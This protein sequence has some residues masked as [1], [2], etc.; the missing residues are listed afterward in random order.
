[1]SDKPKAGFPVIILLCVFLFIL[2]YHYS[3]LFPFTNNAFVV[4]NVRP[5]TANVKGYITNIYIKNEQEVKKG[6]PLFTVFKAPYELA[7]RKAVSD[8]QEAKAQLLLFNK[9]VEKT[10]YLLQAQK[11]LYEKFRFDYEHNHSALR[12]HAV[13]KLTVNTMLKE[14]NAALSKLKA[15][16]KELEVNQQQVIVQ[17]KK[18]DSLIAVMK[19][20]KIDLDE[21]TVYA[22]QNGAVQDM[23]VALGTP[24]KTRKPVFAIADTDTLFIQAN[25]N[26]TDLRRVQPGDKVSIFPRMYFGSKIYH[27]V[28]LSRNWA[29][30]RLETHRATQIQIVRNSESNWFLLPQR[31]PVQI[32]ITDYDPV[33]YPLSIGASVYVYIHTH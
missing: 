23:F 21:T 9:Q 10:K 30:S 17:K 24:I 20:A 32:Q 13:S 31:L 25:F 29:A 22:K 33:H 8:V 12:D 11:E 2:I 7:Y 15:L 19:N 6:Q 26:E 28:I 3:Y 27:G 18:I 5:V 14:K 1:M 16:E 4:A